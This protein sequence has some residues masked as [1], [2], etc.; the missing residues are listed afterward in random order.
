MH[1]LKRDRRHL[2]LDEKII[3]IGNQEIGIFEETEKPEICGNCKGQ[4][5][6]SFYARSLR[7]VNPEAED[8]IQAD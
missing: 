4:W 6:F 2:H 1:L 8:I 5:N 7:S 3:E